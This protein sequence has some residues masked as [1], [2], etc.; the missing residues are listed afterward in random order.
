LKKLESNEYMAYELDP[1]I[2][3]VLAAV[4]EKAAEQDA[5]LPVTERGDWKSLREG[6]NTNLAYLGSLLPPTPDVRTT[7]FHT[8]STDGESIELRWYTKKG[9]SPGPAIVYAHGG[10]MILGNVN[11]YDAVVSEYVSGTGVPFLSVNYRLA[12]EVHGP[13]LEED[14]FAGVVWLI[15]RA[16]ELG[17]DPARIAIMGDSGGGGVAAGAAILARDRQVTLARQILIYPML[18]DRN[19]EPDLLLVSIRHLDLRQQLHCLERGPRRRP[20]G[21]VCFAG[22]C[23]GA[24]DRLRWAARRV[25]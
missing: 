21:R 24:T 20:G 7:S 12:P 11:V 13:T 14:V 10:G 22:R 6:G 8:T 23:P 19:L 4:S 16:S 15:G 18:D 1:D 5:D 25:H 17:V 2:A 9:A 3:R